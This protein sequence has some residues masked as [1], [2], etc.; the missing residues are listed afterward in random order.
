MTA[1]GFQINTP[2]VQT[3][4]LAAL[5][6]GG[7][8]VSVLN[9]MT[10]SSNLDVLVQD[11]TLVNFLTLNYCTAPVGWNGPIISSVV[12]PDGDVTRVPGRIGRG[13]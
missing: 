12:A 13:R 9:N 6:R 3:F 11:D 8:T 7:A 5:P 4:N 10:T 2:G 1:A